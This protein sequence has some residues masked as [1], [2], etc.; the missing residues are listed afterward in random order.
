MTMFTGFHKI[1]SHE[2]QAKLLLLDILVCLKVV[3][4]GVKLDERSLVENANSFEEIS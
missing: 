1:R 3:G 4:T 2:T